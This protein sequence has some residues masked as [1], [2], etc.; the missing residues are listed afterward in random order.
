[1]KPKDI[2]NQAFL[3][4]RDYCSEECKAYCC[5]KGYLPLNQEEAK[6]FKGELRKLKDGTYN[7][8]FKRYCP[9]LKEFKCTNYKNR[10]R[11]CRSFPVY[12]KDKQ[13]IFSSKCLAVKENLFYPC[14][15]QLISLGYDV[16]EKEQFDK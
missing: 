15:K 8:F 14:I 3:E 7:F 1:M 6:Q 4:I 13:I 2:I 9:H 16:Q 12:I 10:P 11:A 5:R